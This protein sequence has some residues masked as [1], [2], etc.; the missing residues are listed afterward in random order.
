MSRKKSVAFV[1]ANDGML[2]AFGTTG[3]ELFG[4]IPSS[5]LPKLKELPLSPLVWQPL[6]DGPLTLGDVYVG[7]AWKTILVGGLGG[8]GSAVFGLDVTGVTQTTGSG[9]FA[10]SNVLF[11][12]TDVEMGSNAPSRSEYKAAVTS[13]ATHSIISAAP[14]ERGMRNRA[15]A[16]TPGRHA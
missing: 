7:G 13:A 6:V 12:V 15:S 9:T 10:A 16:S 14:I 2:H 8:G 11:D 3:A 4:Y 1:G 5:V